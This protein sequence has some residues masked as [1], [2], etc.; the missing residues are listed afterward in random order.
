[1]TKIFQAVLCGLAFLP[2]G[3]C[4][5]AG[6]ATPPGVDGDAPI[7]IPLT[8]LQNP[9]YGTYSPKVSIALGNGK[10]LPFVLDTG[11]T[12]LHV[13][14]DANLA[15][16]R[17]AE[18][19]VPQNADERDVRQPCAHHAQRRHLQ[20]TASCIFKESRRPPWY[21]SAY[22][23][24]ASCPST[25]PTCRIP[26]LHNPTAMGG[27]GILGIG[28]TN[29]M[30]AAAVPSPIPLYAGA[31]RFRVQHCPRTHDVGSLELGGTEPSRRR[32]LRSP[33]PEPSPANSI[34]CRE[35]ACSSTDEKLTHA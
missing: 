15:E 24:S 25:N 28:L 29:V 23:T 5:Q 3:G 11:S 1:M 19:S 22:L 6:A 32:R 27:Y 7:T 13:Y 12:G 2:I 33:T 30:S 14:A 21:Q 8:V 26:D 34:R 9:R 31:S 17:G 18:R 4:A 10:P 20:R 16:R 35:L